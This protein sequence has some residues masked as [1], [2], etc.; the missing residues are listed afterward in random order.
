MVGLAPGGRCVALRC[1][2]VLLQCAQGCA[3]VDVQ[4]LSAKHQGGH[5]LDAGQGGFGDPVLDRA[6]VQNLDVDS[7]A[8]QGAE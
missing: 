2:P 5:G 8:I 4:G 3:A 1:L 7:R 6:E